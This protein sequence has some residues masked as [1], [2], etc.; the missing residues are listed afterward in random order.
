MIAVIA[1]K[2][3][4]GH[5]NVMTDKGFYHPGKTPASV[6]KDFEPGGDPFPVWQWQKYSASAKE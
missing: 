6:E 2:F 1:I 3:E 5:K 4:S